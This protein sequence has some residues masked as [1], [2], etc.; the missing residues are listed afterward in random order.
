[1]TDNARIEIASELAVPSV[2]Q[3]DIGR[4]RAHLSAGHIRRINAVNLHGERP[5]DDIVADRLAFVADLYRKAGLRPRLR[6]TSMDTWIDPMIERWTEA[7]DALVMTIEP[8]PADVGQTISIDAWLSWLA[9]RAASSGRFDEAAASAR[10]LDPN[11][12]VVT[13]SAGGDIVGAARAVS[14]NGLTGLFDIMVD[15]AHRRR[16][17][18][19][20]MIDRLRGWAAERGEGVYLQVAAVNRPAI[21]LYR[22]MGFVERY[23]YR[24]RS[25]N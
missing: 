25:P 1:M 2:R 4:W 16:G 3:V 8:Q 17:H 5:E 23:R 13:V 9:P 20:S 6:T 19:R 7:G 21:T 14:A 10:R 24:Y 15:P 11:N 12:I 22:A 18:A